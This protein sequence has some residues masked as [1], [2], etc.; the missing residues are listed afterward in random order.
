GLVG[1]PLPYSQISSSSHGASTT[2]LPLGTRMVLS[3]SILVTTIGV[4]GS[5]YTD[6][7]CAPG[8]KAA[9]K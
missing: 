2:S 9:S 6:P 4:V 1:S 8:V 7:R 5:S 3:S